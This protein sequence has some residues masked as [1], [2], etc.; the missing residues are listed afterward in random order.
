MIRFSDYI[1]IVFRK[2]VPA[3]DLSMLMLFLTAIIKCF[4]RNS[5]ASTSKSDSK[6]SYTLTNQNGTLQFPPANTGGASIFRLPAEGQKP[7]QDESLQFSI[8]KFCQFSRH[9]SSTR[10][11]HPLELLLLTDQRQLM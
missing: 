7:T 10:G 2:A 5:T 9:F 8:Q 1:S 4:R 11:I 6:V 3:F